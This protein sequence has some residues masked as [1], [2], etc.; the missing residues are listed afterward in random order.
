M[1]RAYQVSIALQSFDWPL[2]IISSCGWLVS[3][4]AQ[5]VIPELDFFANCHFNGGFANARALYSLLA[6]QLV[7]DSPFPTTC[8]ID[9]HL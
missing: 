1:V 5:C 8:D 4:M 9:V 7:A 3:G 2:Q 6:R